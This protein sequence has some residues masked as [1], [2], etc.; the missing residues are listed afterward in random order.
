MKRGAPEPLKW[1][2]MRSIASLR[3]GIVRSL[4]LG[5]DSVRALVSLA[6][7]L[8]TVQQHFGAW[9]RAARAEFPVPDPLRVAQSRESSRPPVPTGTR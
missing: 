5:L 1:R 3:V 6:E 4:P 2:L 9:E 7:E 8:W